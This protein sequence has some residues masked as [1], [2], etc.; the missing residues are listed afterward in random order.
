MSVDLA[1]PALPPVPVLFPPAA[2]LSGVEVLGAYREQPA[3]T[4]MAAALNPATIVRRETPGAGRTLSS[5][6]MVVS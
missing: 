1:M 6:S 4:V 5:L 2:V 3:S